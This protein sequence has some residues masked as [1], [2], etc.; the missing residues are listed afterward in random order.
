MNL[1][2]NTDSYKISHYLQYP[3]DVNYVS[4][5]IE[6]RGG[7]WNRVL[8]YGLQMFLME[9]LSKKITYED[10]EEAKD[11][12]KFHGLSFNEDSWRYIVDEHGGALPLEIEA[13]K[14]GSIVQTDN[15]LLQIRNTDPKLPWLVGYLETAILR[16]IWY[17]VAVATNS[18]FC[19][20]NILQ[21]LN[22]TG[23]PDLIDFCLHDFGARGVSS[24]E[25]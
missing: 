10:I 3:K 16:A 25:S 4:S 19:K 7:R 2:L 18:Y 13:V 5:Y 8:F 9:Y 11:F 15:V 21:F 14:E 20:Q 12:I 22:E 24:F 1:I 17:P 6:S 23:T